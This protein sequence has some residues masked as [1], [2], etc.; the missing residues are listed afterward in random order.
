MCVLLFF[1]IDRTVLQYLLLTHQNIM[2]NAAGQGRKSAACFKCFFYAITDSDI[3]WVKSTNT[4]TSDI[5]HNMNFEKHESEIVIKLKQ[6][7]TDFKYIVRNNTDGK[8]LNQLN[9]EYSKGIL[10]VS[11]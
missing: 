3:W 10:V 6:I 4:V 9:L 5:P 11:Q 7:R 8:K 1:F 2:Q